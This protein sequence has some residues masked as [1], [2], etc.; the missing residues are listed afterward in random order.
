[1]RAVTR[2]PATALQSGDKG[3][4]VP[5][6]TTESGAVAARAAKPAARAPDTGGGSHRLSRNS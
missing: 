2:R 5:K 1:M 3:L 4:S 6:A